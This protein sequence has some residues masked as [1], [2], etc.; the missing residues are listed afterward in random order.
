LAGPIRSQSSHSA[1]QPPGAGV[2]RS[3]LV[4]RAIGILL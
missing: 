2:V 3:N 1:K 4:K